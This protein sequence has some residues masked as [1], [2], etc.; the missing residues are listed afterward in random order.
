MFF[1][2]DA[3]VGDGE[4]VD[5]KHR[6]PLGK[7]LTA[8]Q[9][10]IWRMRLPRSEGGEGLTVTE[11]AVALGISASVVSNTM[12]V[13]NKKLGVVRER[14]GRG[15]HGAQHR[16]F[17]HTDPPKAAAALEAA[18]AIPGL[19]L[20]RDAI[21]ASGLP[22]KAGLALVRRLEVQYNGVTTAVRNLKKHELSELLGNKIHLL[23]SYIDDKSAADANVRDLSLGA[24][25]LIEKKQLVDGQPTVIL[26]D[27]D[28]KRLHELLPLIIAEG[29]RRGVTVEG[30]VL[31]KEVTVEPVRDPA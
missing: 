24:A 13:C 31:A 17:E 6:G 5:L 3:P 7:S 14:Y 9:G 19:Q 20:V 18:G 10:A 28:R 2:E 16:G 8:R 21:A 23:L 4:P 25:Q 15:H 29:R 30:R 26:S 27:A 1:L 12:G 11:V 22:E